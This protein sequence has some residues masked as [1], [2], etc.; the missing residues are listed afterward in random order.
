[1]PKNFIQVRR[2]Q[3]FLLPDMREWLPKDHLAWFVLEAA[4]KM[5]LSAFMRAFATTVGAAP[6]SNRR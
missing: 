1:M 6:R 2:D 4:G 3:Q 5:D